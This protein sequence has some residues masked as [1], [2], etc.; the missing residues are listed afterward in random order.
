MTVREKSGVIEFE[1]QKKRFERC[2]HLRVLVRDGFPAELY[3][4]S[5]GDELGVASRQVSGRHLVLFWIDHEVLAISHESIEKC[6]DIVSEATAKGFRTQLWK[7]SKYLPGWAGVVMDATGVELISDPIGRLPVF[8]RSHKDFEIATDPLLL[9]DDLP[10]LRWGGLNAYLLID[11]LPANWCPWETIHRL[12]AGARVVRTWEAESSRTFRE[13]WFDSEAVNSGS[14]IGELWR[15]VERRINRGVTA[16][17]LSGG[18]D[19]SLLVLL[20]SEMGVRVQVFSMVA[21]EFPEFDEQD[22][23]FETAKLVGATFRP[24]DISGPQQWSNQAVFHPVPGWGPNLIAEAPYVVP[25]LGFVSKQRCDESSAIVFGLGA[26]QI[27]LHTQ[28]ST[29]NDRRLGRVRRPRTASWIRDHPYSDLTRFD[30]E[31]RYSLR[32]LDF[33]TSGSW[34]IVMHSLERYRRATGM[35]LELPYLDPPV[36]AAATTEVPR[37]FPDPSTGR[38]R[39]K[40]VLREALAPKLPHVAFRGKRGIFDPIVRDG[41]TNH[42]FPPLLEIVRESAV[43]QGIPGLNLPMLLDE[44]ARDPLPVVGPI[45]RA[46]VLALWGRCFN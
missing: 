3:L 2:S 35:F 25:F 18:V 29:S 38:V 31:E 19:S 8:F 12:E 32:P 7:V 40:A 16:F 5:S 43:L 26:D 6:L 34:S 21:P 33:R 44:L 10:A 41:L 36:L 37:E 11:G 24:F 14:L 27:L 46:M 22:V 39:R 30:L 1:G 20:A 28:P 13:C 9:A 45:Q 42:I 4:D 23:A 17:S 15:A